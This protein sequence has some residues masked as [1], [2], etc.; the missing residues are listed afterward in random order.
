MPP[1]EKLRFEFDGDASKFESAINKSQK[2]VNTFSNSLK[3]VGGVIAGVFAVDKLLSFGRAIIDTTAN[4]E[5]MEAVLTTTLGSQSSAQIAMDQIVDFASTTPFQIDELTDSFVKLANRG[6]IPTENEMRALGDLASSTGKTFDQLTEAVLDAMTGENE[7]L[8]E[9]GI[10]GRKNGEQI[11]YTFK[12]VETQVNFTANAIKDYLV[13][14]GDVEG[15]SGSMNSI[16]LTLAGRLSNLE[17]NFVGLMNEMGKASKGVMVS[18]ID[19]LG[20]MIT[21]LRN[22]DAFMEQLNPFKDFVDMSEKTQMALLK[23]GITASGTDISSITRQFDDLTSTQEQ[24]NAITNEGDNLRNLFIE[25]FKGEG[26]SIETLNALYDVYLRKRQED[27]IKT[28]QLNELRKKDELEKITKAQEKVLEDVDKKL[29]SVL[30]TYIVTEGQINVTSESIKVL[31]KSMI[32]LLDLGL[33]PTNERFQEL[34]KKLIFFKQ[35]SNLIKQS[36][37]ELKAESDQLDINTLK[38]REY[39]DVVDKT[40]DGQKQFALVTNIVT[41]GMNLMFDALSDPEGFD[42]FVKGIKKVIV[43]LLKQLAIMTAISAIFAL[44]TG[45]SFVDVFKS[46]SGLGKPSEKFSMFAKGGIVTAPTMG[47]VGEGGQSEAIIPLN[48]L[49]QIMGSMGGNQ[50]GEFTLRGQD[51]I[52]ALERAGDFR[53]RITG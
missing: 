20:N 50:R 24:L 32:K 18:V 26:E 45:K 46:V 41:S 12:G 38:K 39:L 34:N 47:I 53:T 35:E 19:G 17:D 52:L 31:Q 13:S 11:T 10:I 36:T 7:R 27:I 14:L 48:R 22:F 4:F 29:K 28:E 5:K 37:I 8:K 25:A 1:V 49:P 43:Q 2:S 23:V 33:D 16:S 40:V 3:Q 51:L 42:T 15:V 44:V 9:F 6:F 30:N 21:H